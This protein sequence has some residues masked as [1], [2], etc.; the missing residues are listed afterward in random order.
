MPSRAGHDA[1][2][3]GRFTDMGMIFVPSEG[4]VS[5]SEIEYTTPE[6]CEQWSQCAAGNP[7]E[8]RS[9]LPVIWP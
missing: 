2:E 8:T 3:M 5:H 7:A 4:G 6:E 1:L 9:P